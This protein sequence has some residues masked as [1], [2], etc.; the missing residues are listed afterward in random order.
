[1]LNYLSQ[2]T[3]LSSSTS[4]P[5]EGT[6]MCLFYFSSLTFLGPSY[7]ELN[8]KSKEYEASPKFGVNQTIA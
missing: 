7:S 4:K 2:G 3:T 5:A 1:M 8:V 6:L